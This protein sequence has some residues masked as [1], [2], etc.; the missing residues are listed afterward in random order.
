MLQTCPLILFMDNFKYLSWLL[1]S[2]GV[3]TIK[4][5]C[6][7]D[8]IIVDTKVKSPVAYQ[9]IIKYFCDINEDTF[10]IKRAVPS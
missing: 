2:S 6:I 3:L 8:N 7:Y 10:Q 1:K 4:A 9:E 5:F